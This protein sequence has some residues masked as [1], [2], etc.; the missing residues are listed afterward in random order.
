MEYF[1]LDAWKTISGVSDIFTSQF[2][3]TILYFEV[4]NRVVFPLC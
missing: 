1:I 2:Y 3:N 4:A